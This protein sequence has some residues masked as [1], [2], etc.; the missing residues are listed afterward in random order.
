MLVLRNASNRRKFAAGSMGKIMDQVDVLPSNLK[1]AAAAV[2]LLLG[3]SITGSHAQNSDRA[4]QT[5][6]AMV[7]TLSVEAETEMIGGSLTGCHFVYTAVAQDS[8]HRQGAY[9]GIAGKVGVRKANNNFGI[10]LKVVVFDIDSS[11]PPLVLKPSAPSRAYLVDHDFQTNLSSLVS[12][13]PSDTPGALVS[14]FQF[15]PS[16]EIIMNGLGRY[17]ITIA[18]NRDEGDTDIQLPLELDVKSVSESGQ[19]QRSDEAVRSFRGCV[20]SMM[21]QGAK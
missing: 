14:L 15:H 9:I 4:R 19:R 13:V 21:P 12:T 7:G 8:T 18:F 5:L 6:S 20:K 11:K 3:L 16:F 1:L 10:D 17:K 2:P